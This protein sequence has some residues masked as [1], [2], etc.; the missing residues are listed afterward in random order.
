MGSLTDAP[1]TLLEPSRFPADQSSDPS[2]SAM[3][4]NATHK[5]HGLDYK[6]DPWWLECLDNFSKDTLNPI[7]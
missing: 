7:E 3:A 2:G 4:S 6:N 1:P 5:L